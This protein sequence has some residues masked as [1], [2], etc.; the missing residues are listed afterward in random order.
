MGAGPRTKRVDT[1][2]FWELQERVQDCDLSIRANDQRKHYV[3]LFGTHDISHHERSHS[4]CHLHRFV[5]VDNLGVQGVGETQTIQ[6]LRI[7]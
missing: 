3:E 5:F 6:R 1:R 7:L 2:F 4:A